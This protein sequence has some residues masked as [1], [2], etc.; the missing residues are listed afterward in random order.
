M[1]YLK[2]V[3]YNNIS[4]RSCNFLK[5]K[6]LILENNISHFN[7]DKNNSLIKY[8]ELIKLLL[9]G[10]SHYDIDFKS[11]K[12]LKSFE[13]DIHYFL[14]LENSSSLKEVTLTKYNDEKNIFMNTFKEIDCSKG[15]YEKLK[16]Y[17]KIHSVTKLKINQDNILNLNDFLNIFPNLSDL[18]IETHSYRY[19][20]RKYTCGYEPNAGNKK[21]II[22][23]NPNSKITNIKFVLL[24]DDGYILKFNCQPFNKLKS[25]D[26]YADILDIDSLDCL[27]FFK[28]K[29]DTLFNSLEIFSFTLSYYSEEFKKEKELIENLYNN[30]DKMPNLIDFHFSFFI[31]ENISEN[32][33]KKFI[34]KVLTLKSIKKI[35]IKIKENSWGKD[36][37]YS[38]DALKKFFPHINFNKFHKVNIYF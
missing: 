12:K 9:K 10:N 7:E 8:P 29:C 4:F 36:S 11:L 16:S 15:K 22:T 5:L 32:F 38:K 21:V 25:F 24:G 34:K 33:Y 20:G 14:L 37:T 30:I 2:L 35:F 3:S 31:I 28:N 23:E 18:I 13:G 27:P 26:L 19:Y 17:K 6:Y 1:K